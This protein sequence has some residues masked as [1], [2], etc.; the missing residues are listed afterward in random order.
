MSEL[1]KTIESIRK[2]FPLISGSNIAYLDNAATTQKPQ[3]VLDAVNKYYQEMNAN[4]FRGV[5]E[6]SEIATESYENARKAVA[7]FIGAKDASQIVFT[8]NATE[9]LNLIAYS[10]GMNFIKEGDEIVV[11]V[12]EHH[13][14]FLPWKQVAE[15]CGAVLKQLT[16]DE[17]G[18][19]T[20]KSLEVITDKTRLVA[21]TQ[22]SNVLGRVNDIKHIAE[23]AHAH[24]AVIVADGAQSVPHMP[25]NVT[26]LDVDFLVF[27]GHKML[28]PMGIG[29]LYGK[30]DILDKM[31]F[32]FK[33]TVGWDTPAYT[34]YNE[35]PVH[36]NAPTMI[37]LF[38]DSENSCAMDA[39]IMVENIAIAAESIGLG[40][41]IIG[42]VRELFGG[43]FADK[44]YDILD[45]PKTNPFMIAISVGYKAENPEPKERK[46]NMVKIIK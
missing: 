10:Y 32:D 13:S 35:N 15:K 18:E 27:S 34:R 30:K 1:S 22:V 8:R 20:D 36:H 46:E 42:S 31:N 38:A 28:A 5:Y 11:S 9:S 19:I 17:N 2:D 21:V 29:A 14:N 4:P 33:E 23:V 24:G 3:A 12:M 41:A 37:F 26:D 39:G 40:T 25:V 6:L 16:P 7:Q 43:Q 44:W 45:I